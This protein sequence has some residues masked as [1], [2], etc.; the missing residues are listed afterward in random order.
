MKMPEDKNV[1]EGKP[2]PDGD[3]DGM[4]DAWEK[5]KKGRDLAPNG[6]DLDKRYEN[7]EVYLQDRMEQL[8][9]KAAAV[10]AWQQIAGGK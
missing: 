3:G 4:P 8:V 2:A 5:K 1:Y 7:I 10:K 9:D 6:H